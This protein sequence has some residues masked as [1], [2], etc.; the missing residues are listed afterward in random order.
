MISTSSRRASPKRKLALG[1]FPLGAIVLCAT[2][3]WPAGVAL[4][5]TKSPVLS[6]S[7]HP[8]LGTR[9]TSPSGY[10]LSVSAGGALAEDLELSNTSHSTENFEASAATAITTSDS[11]AAYLGAFAPCRATACWVKGLPSTV[12]IDAGVSQIASFTVAAPSGT[13]D[14][15]YVAGIAVRVVGVTKSGTRNKVVPGHQVDL[16]VVATVGR[17]SSLKTRFAITKIA[18][19]TSGSEAYLYVHEHNSGQTFVSAKGTL[20][21][22]RASKRFTYTIAPSD[23]L[24]A[25]AVASQVKAVGLPTSTAVDCSARLEDTTIA[26]TPAATFVQVV[27]IPKAKQHKSS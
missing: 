14:G 20:V 19:T 7:A 24:P 25:G 27:S 9:G 4:S 11:S 1:A 5:A 15:Q 6:F 3:L 13:H 10:S 18:A 21:C 26:K 8:V 22:S 2:L 23:L 16:R 12:K 17:L